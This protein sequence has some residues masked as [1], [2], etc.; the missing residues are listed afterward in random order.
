M[1]RR[2]TKEEEREKKEELENFYVVQNRTIRDAASILGIAESSAFNRMRRLGI[3][4]NPERKLRY[5]NKRLDIKFPSLCSGLAE[6]FGVMLG[7]GHLQVGKHT[8]QVWIYVNNITDRRYVPYLQDLLKSLFHVTARTSI[9][10]D[11]NVVCLFISSVELVAYLKDK[12][13]SCANKVVQQADAPSWVFNK[14]SYQKAFLR[15]FFDTDGSIYKLRFGVQMSFC[16]RA[17]P[18]L[19]STR[20]MLLNLKFHP[21][22]ISGSNLYLTRKPDLYRYIHEIGF[23][24]PKHRF[25]ASKFLN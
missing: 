11:R 3:V 23:G 19:K 13:L 21:S 12:G 8:N 24:N 2:W 1:A 9:R 4:S 15:G 16:N 22:E 5:L 17:T 25:R 7:D 14:S 6:F 20:K 18:L 10:R